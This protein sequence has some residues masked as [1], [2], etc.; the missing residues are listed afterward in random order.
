MYLKRAIAASVDLSAVMGQTAAS[1]G[2]TLAKALEDPINNLSALTRAGAIYRARKK[3]KIAT[4]KR[5][6]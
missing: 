5:G 6:K 4:F 1:A 3:E 2:K